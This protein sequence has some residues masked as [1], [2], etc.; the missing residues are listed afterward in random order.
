MIVC[1]C[2]DISDETVRKLVREGATRVEQIVS[3]CAAGAYCGVCIPA[4]LQIL[5][6][7]K[8]LMKRR[9]QRVSPSR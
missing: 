7:E 8:H 1:P 5:R 2:D 3:A 6:H 9:S 4:I